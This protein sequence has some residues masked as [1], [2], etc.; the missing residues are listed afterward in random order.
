[1]YLNVVKDYNYLNQAT[2]L[3]GLSS[4]TRSGDNKTFEYLYELTSNLSYKEIIKI[5]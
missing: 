5:R 3:L 4:H 1:M 2:D